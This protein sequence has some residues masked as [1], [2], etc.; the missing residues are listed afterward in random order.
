MLVQVLASQEAVKELDGVVV[1]FAPA[2]LEGAEAFV[3]ELHAWRAWSNAAR[4]R[5]RAYAWI[6]TVA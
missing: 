2:L 4:S 1:V 3:A 5:R 6:P